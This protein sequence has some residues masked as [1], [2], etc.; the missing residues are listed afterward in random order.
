MGIERKSCGVDGELA[1]EPSSDTSEGVRQMVRDEDGNEE[2]LG[3][4]DGWTVGRRYG[5]GQTLWRLE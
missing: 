1:S 5:T 3:E 2:D 4:V